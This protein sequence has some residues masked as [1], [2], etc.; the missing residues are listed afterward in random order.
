M[1][2]PFWKKTKFNSEISKKN[3]PKGLEYIEAIQ[4]KALETLRLL[5]KAF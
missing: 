3:T 2:I 5:F 4:G 1:R